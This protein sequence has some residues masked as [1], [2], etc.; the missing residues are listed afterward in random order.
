MLLFGFAA[1]HGLTMGGY[2]ILHPMMVANYFGRE[3]LGGIQGVL[4]PFTTTATAISPILVATAYDAQGSYFWGFFGVMCAYFM[5][6]GVIGLAKHP[7]RGRQA[8]SN[9]TK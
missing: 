3:N 8:Q 9:A 6:S 5:A 7:R 4:R 1:F 2:F